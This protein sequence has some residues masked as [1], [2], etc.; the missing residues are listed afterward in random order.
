MPWGALIG[1]GVALYEGS[2]SNKAA[3]DGLKA[4]DRA[5]QAAIDEQR[6]QFDLTR[7]D[8]APWL[9]AGTNALGL[10]NAFLHGDMSG[11]Q[12][13]PDYKYALQSGL[14]TID[15][16][17]A[18]RGGLFGGGNTRDAMRF[19]QG[20]ATQN[21]NSYWDKISG[22]SNTGNTT[23]QNL[24]QFGANMATSIGNQYNSM[25]NARQSM[26]NQVAQNNGQTAAAVG[27][28]INQYGQYKGWWG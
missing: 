1:A 8:M 2:Q 13:S 24:G 3:K 20:L 14:D 9:T 25:G 15:H 27:G 16:R 17:A 11:F 28:A 4:T 22:M 18:A 5:S 26:Y 21:A 7:S 12:N 10:Q 23:G 19:G 6:R